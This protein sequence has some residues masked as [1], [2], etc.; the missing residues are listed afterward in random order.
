MWGLVVASVLF[1]VNTFMTGS[2]VL[3]GIG[4]ALQVRYVAVAVAARTRAS[5]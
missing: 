4:V 5:E 2:G 3:F 1:Y